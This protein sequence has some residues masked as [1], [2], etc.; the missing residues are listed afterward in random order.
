MATITRPAPRAKRGSKPEPQAAALEFSL[1]MV[2]A[3]T[4]TRW[5]EVNV[6]NRTI[7]KRKIV[8]YRRDMLGGNW[9]DVGDPVRFD[10]DENM[11]D[12]QHRMMALIQAD[13]VQPGIELE[14]LVVR[15]V[16]SEDR[17][18]IDT[19]TKRTAGDQLK[20]AG[21]QHPALLASA[22]KWC[23]MWDRQAVYGDLANR[24]V[25][26][27]EILEYVEQNPSLL[28]I[29]A[30]VNN[31]MKTHIDMPPG[32]IVTAYFLCSRLDEADAF[33]FF[34]RLTDGAMLAGG[35]PILA[36]R[37]RLRDLDRNRANLSGEMWLS[38]VFRAWNAR[39]EGR[40]MRVLPLD[41]QGKPIPA[42][43]LK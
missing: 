6:S 19:G 25:T 37:S 39:R 24:S 33:E 32:Y 36:L 43:E 16:Q 34:E 9:R 27:A 20:M 21:Y 28:E 26:H 12:G 7:R 14:F 38:L 10:T 29:A 23:C 8:E 2:N 30:A 31:R 22:A 5:L 42:P 4:A 18:V 13:E 35:D 41:R 17:A 11:C 15:G 3:E 40:S 1:E